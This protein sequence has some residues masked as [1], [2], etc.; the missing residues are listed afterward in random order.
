MTMKT[1][2]E[3]LHDPIMFFLPLAFADHAF[4]DIAS[5]DQFWNIRPPSGTKQFEFQW[6]DS[7]L[8]E[9]VFRYITKGN[10]TDEPWHTG[11]MYSQLKVLVQAAGYRKGSITIHTLRRGFANAIFSK[12]ESQ[13]PRSYLPLRLP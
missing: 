1:R 13:I 6:R 5:V 8:D 12:W 2:E 3:L 9:P 11:Q 4:K 10:V 7:I